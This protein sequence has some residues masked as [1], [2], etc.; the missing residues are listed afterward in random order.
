MLGSGLKRAGERGG[1]P[2]KGGLPVRV[3]MGT[4]SSVLW[5]GPKADSACYSSEVSPEV[6]WKP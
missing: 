1:D 4:Q 5:E 6:R 3:G 2:G